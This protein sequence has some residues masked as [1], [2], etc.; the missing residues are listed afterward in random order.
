MREADLGGRAMRVARATSG[1]SFASQEPEGCKMETAMDWDRIERNWR[2]LEGAV[3]DKWAKLTEEELAAINGHR[4]RLEGKIQERYG[5]DKD[6]AQ[7]E[8]DDWYN[9]LPM[10]IFL[11]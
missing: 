2:Q 8:I 4:D 3:K 1:I 10:D 7:K 5:Y 11:P 6:R 9:G